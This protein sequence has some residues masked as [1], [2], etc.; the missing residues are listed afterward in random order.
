MTYDNP[1]PPILAIRVPGS[2]N[3]TPQQRQVIDSL[4]GELEASGYTVT[5]PIVKT[6]SITLASIQVVG[7]YLSGKFAEKAL[8]GAIGSLGNLVINWLRSQ[9]RKN[10]PSIAAGKT[11]TVV[12]FSHDGKPL[13]KL[14]LPDDDDDE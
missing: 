2:Q 9:F 11:R 13:L 8:D 1:V 12:F 5:Q 7:I 6:A 10:K 3:F 14:E 4:R